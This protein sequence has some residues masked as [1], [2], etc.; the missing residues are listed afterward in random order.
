MEPPDRRQPT[1]LDLS[2]LS[3]IPRTRLAGEQPGPLHWTTVGPSAAVPLPEHVARSS[4][5]LVPRRYSMQPG[6]IDLFKV[7]VT[8]QDVFGFQIGLERATDWLQRISL[9]AALGFVSHW[10]SRLQSYEADQ[11]ALGASFAQTYFRGDA[12]ARLDAML[13]ADRYVLA[14]QV[15]LVMLKIS[16]F[17]CPSDRSDDDGAEMLP[18]AMLAIAGA[19]GAFDDQE[20]G[21]GTLQA[22]IVANQ[23]FNSNHDLTNTMALFGY[24]WTTEDETGSTLED[25]YLDATGVRLRD[26]AAVALFLWVAVQNGT[27]RVTRR[28]FRALNWSADRL[29]SALALISAPLEVL[30]ASIYADEEA[31]GWNAIR[32]LFSPLERYPVLQWNG[33]FVVISPRFL[34][35]RAFGWPA[36]FDLEASLQGLGRDR[37]AARAIGR[38]R[39]KT[40]AYAREVL[41]SIASPAAGAA[42]RVFHEP[43]LQSAFGRGGKTADAAIDYGDAW[44]VVEISTRRLARP[45]VYGQRGALEVEINALIQKCAQIDATIKQLRFDDSR[46][47]GVPRLQGKRF[48]PVL[49]MTEGYAVNPLVNARLEEVL[50]MKHLLS[51]RDTDRVEVMDLQTLE[52]I[53]SIG[54]AGGPSFLELIREKRV[55]GMANASMWDYIVVERQYSGERSSRLQASWAAPFDWVIDA[56][57]G[58]SADEDDGEIDGAAVDP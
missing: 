24:R 38:L 50:R 49:V 21:D 3:E 34:E 35:Q 9:P 43:Q 36:A 5:L 30:K 16:L 20:G 44:L 8:D 22:E 17:Q 18:V 25:A 57:G 26:V 10:L 40:E 6:P 47:T 42:R 28:H 27:V 45:V 31:E 48:H 55:S 46:L 23:H 13:A 1:Q 52:L 39:A 15:L 54:E 56:L 37:D 53:E 19:L 29:E 7:Y 51:G 11:A 58:S 2:L 4:G 33:D 32:W 12:R 41:E 14:P